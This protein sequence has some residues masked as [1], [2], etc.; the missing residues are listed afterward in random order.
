MPG[1]MPPGGMPPGGMPPGGM[2][3]RRAE[4][5][6]GLGEGTGMRDRGPAPVE[7]IQGQSGHPT[8]GKKKQRG[9]EKGHLEQA[10][11]AISEAHA[12]VN[13]KRKE[14]GFKQ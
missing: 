11:D 6:A 10:L 2:P 1:G 9:S 12:G 7:E 4:P 14:S 13:G 8:G 3:I 5:M